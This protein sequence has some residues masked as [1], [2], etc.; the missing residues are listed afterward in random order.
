MHSQLA[1]NHTQA[2]TKQER[3]REQNAEQLQQEG[4]QLD[5][6]SIHAVSAAEGSNR[7]RLPA[8]AAASNVAGNTGSSGRRSERYKIDKKG[9]SSQFDQQALCFGVSPE[10]NLVIQKYK[11][12]FSPQFH[13]YQKDHQAR[14]VAFK[15]N[16]A[17]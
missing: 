7:R 17:L 13:Q 8:G 14:K 12:K 3:D 15:Q 4:G 1:S 11:D 16:E 6:V 2:A 9:S 5:S 10:N